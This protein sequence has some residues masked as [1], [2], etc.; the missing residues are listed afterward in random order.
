MVQINFALREVNCKIVYYGPG[1][2]GKTT[3]LEIIHA[4]A[5]GEFRGDL[6]SIATEGDRTLFFDFLP[7]NLGT[8]AG[9]K[10]KFQLYTVPGQVFYNSTRKLVL[11]GVD[12]IVFVADSRSSKLDENIESLENL[13]EN[14]QEYGLNLETIPHVIQYNKRDLADILPVEDLEQKINPYSA[15]Y[16]EAAA[17]TGQGVFPT[18]KKLAGMVLENLNRQQAASSVA[19]KKPRAVKEPV[20]ATAGASAGGAAGTVEPAPP[21]RRVA[22]RRQPEREAPAAGGDQVV[23]E[24]VASGVSP[25]E[26]RVPVKRKVTP[27]QARNAAAG[28]GRAA[29]RTAAQPKS[30]P[31]A[32][33]ARPP[34]K[35]R[36][37]VLYLFMILVLLAGGAEAVLRVT[38][39]VGGVGLVQYVLQLLGK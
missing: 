28:G 1:L 27:R 6:T 7:L 36:K 19:R 10:T 30:A 14:L 37:T 4:K 12:G 31:A 8:V 38:D 20:M 25:V 32:E 17:V 3:N 13:Q 11:Q 24:R 29:R 23:Q 34:R 5:P 18:L 39:V 15:P 22:A 33:A 26:R 35:R 2:S 21:P 9:M 16:M